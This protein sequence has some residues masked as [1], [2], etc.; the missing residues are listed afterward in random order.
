MPG[1]GLVRFIT[2]Y[3]YRTRFGAAGAL[4]D[5]V[6]FRPLLGWA[7]AWSFD[8]LRLWLEDGVSPRVSASFAISHAISRVA[9]ATVWLFH[10]IVPKLLYPSTGEA[11]LLASSGVLSLR[12]AA[13][14]LPFIGLAEIAFGIVVLVMWRSV[15]PLR[16]NAI[17]ALGLAATVAITSPATLT[18]PF[19]PLTLGIALAALSL[20]GI[21]AGPFVPSAGRCLRRA[22]R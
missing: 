17:A 22:P 7:T 8:R 18:A 11:E 13:A 4:A 5:R 15:V 12:D 1:D 6:A 21:R 2:W 14:I 9:I 16:L 10:G 19:E 3:D 20:V